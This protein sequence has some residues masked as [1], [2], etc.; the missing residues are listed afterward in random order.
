[1][2]GQ[3]L[4]LVA[5]TTTRAGT[6][7]I[8][9]GTAPQ[10]ASDGKDIVIVT[11]EDRSTTNI[12]TIASIA[13]AGLL[14]GAVGVYFNLDG[15]SESD[16]ISAGVP[17]TRPWLPSDQAAADQASSD[18][19]KTIVF[20]SLGGALIAGAAVML[21]LTDPGS[22][23][24]VIHPHTAISPLPGGAIAMHEWTF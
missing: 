22:T 10:T 20:Y 7:A 5:A 2:E 4:L 13:G 15:K 1:M 9:G 24:T 19:T 17:T 3:L 14:V 6:A 21:I 18:R 11:P 23:K 12:V 8:P 16:K